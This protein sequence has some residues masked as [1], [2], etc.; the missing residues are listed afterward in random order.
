MQADTSLE[1]YARHPK[2]QE[3]ERWICRLH[4]AM[5]GMRT[6]SRDITEF[7]AAERAECMGFTHDKLERNLFVCESN[8]TRVVSHVENSLQSSS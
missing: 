2:R 6:A 4:G 7:H 1:M 5:N 3:K 8:E